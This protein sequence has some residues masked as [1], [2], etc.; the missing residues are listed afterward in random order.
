L[1]HLQIADVHFSAPPPLTTDTQLAEI[2]DNVTNAVRE[3]DHRVEDLI[4]RSRTTG[5]T[6]ATGSDIVLPEANT[7]FPLKG[8]FERMARRRFQRGQLL[9]RGKKRPVWVG[10][11]REDIIENGRI[12]R[13]QKCKILGSKADYPTR[14][15]ALRALEDQLAEINKLTY[16]PRPV[17]TFTEF[18][19]KWQRLV[20]PNLKPSTQPPM[21]SQLRKHLLP[22][23]GE[24]AMRD[25]SGE[26]LQSFVVDCELN[27]K[28]TKNLVGT[29]R[30][31]WNSAKSWGY[32]SHDPFGSLVLLEWDKPEQPAFSPEEIK[33]II[34]ASQ[35]PY[36][37]VYWLVAQTGIRRGEVCA[38]DVGHVDLENCTITVRRTRSGRHINDNKSRKPRVFCISTRLADRLRSFV[39]G[40]GSDEPLFLTPKGKRLHPDNLVKRQLKPTL[41]KLGLKGA[42]HAFR[43]G[44]AT[45]QD[46]LHTPMK[47]RQERLGHAESVTTMGYT[48]LV[49]EDDR[50]LVEQLDDLF[51]PAEAE[52]IL[53][54]NVRKSD[55]KALA[56][57]SQELRIQ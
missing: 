12:R 35:P 25:I 5:T 41:E 48:H 53:C 31:M 38:L 39:E 49:S 27:P 9:L 10:R 42:L 1:T 51:C 28:T 16:R 15:L 4:R 8:D 33:L 34:D 22:A 47:V 11:W 30:I 7:G 2:I 21:R 46:R 24:V 14:K 40:K 18:A 54:A 45:A 26:L 29:L 19:N 36:D 17:A 37:T 44:N 13:V 3:K 23:L 55:K 32:V 50:K 20:L 57:E 56:L 52:G 43:H 6:P